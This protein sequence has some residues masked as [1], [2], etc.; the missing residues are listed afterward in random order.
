MKK[1]G[2]KANEDQME[3][4]VNSTHLSTNGHLRCCISLGADP[5]THLFVFT[6]M[7]G[8]KVY[9]LIK[10][11]GELQTALDKFTKKQ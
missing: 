11:P 9:M 8:D 4:D 3:C 7:Q 2:V 6:V 1:T 10:F 5:R